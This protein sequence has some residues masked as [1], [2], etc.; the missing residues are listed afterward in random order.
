[1]LSL[2]SCRCGR[3][4]R[5]VSGRAAA[6]N[7]RVLLPPPSAVLP[8][9]R[10]LLLLILREGQLGGTLNAGPP[11][12]VCMAASRSALVCRQSSRDVVPWKEKRTSAGNA[13]QQHTPGGVRGGLDLSCFGAI[14]T[15][16]CV[17]CR[18]RVHLQP[19]RQPHAPAAGCSAARNGSWNSENAAQDAYSSKRSCRGLATNTCRQEYRQCGGGWVRR[20]RRCG[21]AALTAK[22]RDAACSTL[23]MLRTFARCGT[24]ALI[25]SAS[26]GGSLTAHQHRPP[27]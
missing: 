24:E 4:P 27:Q 13:R 9:R 6:A 10:L 11:Q 22:Q 1:M 15:S 8:P 16:C 23:S 12:W 18:T 25:R 20:Q 17:R 7:C 2:L 26:S 14:H 19:N 3:G 21:D 5:A